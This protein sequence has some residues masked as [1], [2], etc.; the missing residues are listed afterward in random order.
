[1]NPIQDSATTPGG[2]H[3]R[4]DAGAR[5]QTGR[6][7]LCR[8]S[9][10][11]TRPFVSSGRPI[12][13]AQCGLQVPTYSSRVPNLTGQG[14]RSRFPRIRTKRLHLMRGT[15]Y[16]GGIPAPDH[17]VRAGGATVTQIIGRVHHP[18]GAGNR[19]DWLVGSRGPFLGSGEHCAGMTRRGLAEVSVGEGG[20]Y[21]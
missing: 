7:A 9:L 8:P 12:P 18:S 20:M 3:I 1:M 13:K 10:L 5:A 21:E 15:Q 14:Y 17:T 19:P 11:L 2:H 6:P 16:T 4:R